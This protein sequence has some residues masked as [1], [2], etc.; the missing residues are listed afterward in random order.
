MVYI[1]HNNIKIYKELDSILKKND[2]QELLLY[3]KNNNN[4]FFKKEHFYNACLSNNINIIKY[5]YHKLYNKKININK[6]LYNSCNQYNIKLIKWLSKIDVFN[7]LDYYNCL[8]YCISYNNLKLFKYFVNNYNIS[9]F[10]N[11]HL[12]ESIKNNRYNFIEYIFSINENINLINKNDIIKYTFYTNNSNIINLI[13]NKFNNFNINK[14]HISIFVNCIKKGCFN[15]VS[16]FLESSII[17]KDLK[18]NIYRYLNYAFDSNI[19]DNIKILLSYNYHN[20]LCYDFLYNKFIQYGN[21]EII[22]FLYDTNNTID[23]YNCLCIDFILKNRLFDIF[24]FIIHKNPI[25]KISNLQLNYFILSINKYYLQTILYIDYDK[26]HLFLNFIKNNNIEIYYKNTS[27]LINYLLIHNQLNKINIIKNYHNNYLYTCVIRNVLIKDSFKSNNLECIKYSLSILNK[28]IDDYKNDILFYA[29]LHKINH[30]IY[31]LDKDNEFILISYE[32]S[33]IN[34]IFHNDI[35]LFNKILTKKNININKNSFNLII[36]IIKSSNSTI[37]KIIEN[38]IKYN[39]ITNDNIVDIINKCIEY[40]NFDIIQE[41]QNKLCFS[42]IINHYTFLKICKYGNIKFINWFLDFDKELSIYCNIA[43]NTLIFYEHYDQAIFYYNHKNNNKYI[44][45]INNNFNIIKLIINENNI[46]LI[47]WIFDHLNDYDKYKFTNYIKI[48]YNII[49]LLKH[50]NH[51]ILDYLLSNCDII[52]NEMII[53]L[54]T[55]AFIHYKINILNYLINNFDIEKYNLNL[56]FRTIFLNCIKYNNYQ[57][58]DIII[59]KVNNYNWLN[60]SVLY[61]K[62]NNNIFTY[63]IKNYY[64][65]L[66]VDEDLFFN[67]LYTGNLKCIKIFIENYKG[68]IKYENITDDDYIILMNY[69][70]PKLMNYIYSLHKIDFYDNNYIIKT[71][72]S[73]NKFNILKWILTKFKNEKK[74]I[75]KYYFYYVSILYKNL[76]IIKILYKFDNNE[77]F[78]DYIIEYLTFASCVDNLDIFKWFENKV[79]KTDLLLYKYNIINSAITVNNITILKYILDTYDIDINFNDGIIIRVSFDYVANDII[80]ILF[81]K[82]NTIDVLVKNEIIMRYAIEN[83]DIDIINLL[84]NYNN[85]FNLSIDN[86]YL[87]RISCKTDNIEVVKWLFEKNNNIDYS[88][89]NHEIFYYVCDQNYYE[90]ASFFNEINPEL[91]EIEIK[92]Y[93]IISYQVN[94]KIK[95]TDYISIDTIDICPICLENQSDVITECNHQYCNECINSLNNKNE[96]FICAL[97]RSNIQI[98]KNIKK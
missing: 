30:I 21:L 69:D 66:N 56:P 81:E 44:D 28:S 24:L 36:S 38:K 33:L 76:N 50:D 47:K 71:I 90:I 65:Y 87:F 67:I 7:N 52:N 96:F 29:Y 18:K 45:L 95:I 40:N 59:K 61:D 54:Y 35:E 8:S 12:L 72:I 73:M 88:L 70:N 1:T 27:K 41:L 74:H 53:K 11:N 57:L 26:L 49:E 15:S 63:L 68:I 10:S 62:D 48:D 13:I 16:Y 31:E 46:S 25:L 79:M 23:L 14:T 97:C 64:E 22:S 82:Y 39:D 85:N 77:E 9:I 86:E 43:F 4:L 89:N 91:Y 83:A 98:I 58:I 84:Y 78:N 5:I 6:A 3:H 93:E 51:K 37:F 17:K 42:Q 94:K 34:C 75:N 80:K 20:I 2:I 32:Q 19:I 92:N 60:I 55:Y